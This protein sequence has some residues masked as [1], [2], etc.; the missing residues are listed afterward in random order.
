MAVAPAPLPAPALAGRSR[1]CPRHARGNRL[2]IVPFSAA[3]TENYFVAETPRGVLSI[4]VHAA[5]T[6][7]ELDKKL[8]HPGWSHTLEWGSTV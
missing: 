4:E 2:Q 7:D 6:V 1:R 8:R 3:S 5:C